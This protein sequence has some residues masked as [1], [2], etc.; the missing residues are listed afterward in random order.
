MILVVHV[1]GPPH[2]E[3]Q[4]EYGYL[5]AIIMLMSTLTI[6]YYLDSSGS[7]LDKDNSTLSHPTLTHRIRGAY[8][9]T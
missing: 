9:S 8:F 6:R 5:V 3:R 4:L 7:T 2:S 1:H